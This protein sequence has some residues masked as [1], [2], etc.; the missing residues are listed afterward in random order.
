[1]AAG[2]PLNGQTGVL[3]SGSAGRRYAGSMQLRLCTPRRRV[4]THV[5][6]PH[7]ARNVP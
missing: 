4:E 5:N 2:W 3:E 6:L 1:M 7:G